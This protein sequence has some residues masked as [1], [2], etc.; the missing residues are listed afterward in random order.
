MYYLLE[1]VNVYLVNLP[2]N[3][4][5][6]IAYLAFK[7]VEKLIFEYLSNLLTKLGNF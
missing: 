1:S 2:I 6:I 4:V 3:L 7:K 5:S